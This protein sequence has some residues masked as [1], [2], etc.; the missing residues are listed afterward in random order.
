MHS[1]QIEELGYGYIL[2]N[3]HVL[4]ASTALWVN[5]QGLYT[6]ETAFHESLVLFG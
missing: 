2:T 1:Q 3:D 6:S 4:G 5:G